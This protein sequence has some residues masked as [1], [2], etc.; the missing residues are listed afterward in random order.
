MTIN[1]V[2]SARKIAEGNA[3]LENSWPDTQSN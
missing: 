2:L 3:V 1:F